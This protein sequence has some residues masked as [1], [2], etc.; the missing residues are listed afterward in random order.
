[1]ILCLQISDTPLFTVLV[2]SRHMTQS[3][4]DRTPER[5]LRSAHVVGQRNTVAGLA[6]FG[7]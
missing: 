3:L 6:R 7:T 2:I 5:S 1:M 4:P